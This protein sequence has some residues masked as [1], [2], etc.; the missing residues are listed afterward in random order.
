MKTSSFVTRLIVVAVLGGTVSIAYQL[1][2]KD[3]AEA[4]A[5]QLAP[6]YVPLSQE[7]ALSLAKTSLE[8]RTQKYLRVKEKRKADPCYLE[9]ERFDFRAMDQERHCRNGWEDLQPLVKPTLD[10]AHVVNSH[11]ADYLSSEFEPFQRKVEERGLIVGQ[12][13]GGLLGLWVAI[14]ALQW[15]AGTM[16]P[17]LKLGLKRASSNIQI[18]K[19]VR[20][21]AEAH[22][23]NQAKA[24]ILTL[25]K[26]RDSGLISE[27][28]FIRRKELLRES[29]QG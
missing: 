14:A 2:E 18:G 11:R 9:I 22:R 19:S 24:Q 4:I 28:E 16:F 25:E 3:G 26:L 17:Y 23:F 6:P 8:T 13:L 29:L 15:L 12:G 7:E 21:M 1:F 5:R 27:A 10:V 20:S